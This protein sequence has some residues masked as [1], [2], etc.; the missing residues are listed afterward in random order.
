MLAKEP[1]SRGMKLLLVMYVKFGVDGLKLR[2]LEK[3]LSG[4]DLAI[5]RKHRVMVL[6]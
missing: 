6:I 2:E 3:M 5:E 1:Y 4:R